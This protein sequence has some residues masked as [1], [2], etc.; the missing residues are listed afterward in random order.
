MEFRKRTIL[1]GKIF[2]KSNFYLWLINIDRKVW[3][4]K[5]LMRTI[6]SGIPTQTKKKSASIYNHSFNK[7][8]SY[9]NVYLIP[10]LC[11]N[12]LNSDFFINIC[13]LTI[14]LFPFEMF[15]YEQYFFKYEY[16]DLG[17]VE[18]FIYLLMKFI[19]P[20]QILIY[21]LCT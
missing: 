4:L 16:R 10:T 21:L 1:S 15:F 8:C 7:I 13:H 19:F 18:M 6:M 17:A 11:I 3:L 9:L 14:K 5:F 12:T 2:Q 20:L